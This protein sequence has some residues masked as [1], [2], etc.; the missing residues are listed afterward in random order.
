MVITLCTVD[1]NVPIS[2]SSDSIAVRNVKLSEIIIKHSKI[3]Y[4]EY[5]HSTQYYSFSASDD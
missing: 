4:T 2:D 3:I 5:I 1:H